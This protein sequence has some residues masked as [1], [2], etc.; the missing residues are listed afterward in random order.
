MIAKLPVGKETGLPQEYKFSPDAF[1][2]FGV[3]RCNWIQSNCIVFKYRS[4]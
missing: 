3:C 4:N 2:R 1:N